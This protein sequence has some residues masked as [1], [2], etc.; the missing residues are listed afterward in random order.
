MDI[1][2]NFFIE[3]VIGHWKRLPREVVDASCLSMLKRIIWIV[4]L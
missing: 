1:R 3:K 4:L 2:K